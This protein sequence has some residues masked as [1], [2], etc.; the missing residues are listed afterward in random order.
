MVYDREGMEKEEILD[1]ATEAYTRKLVKVAEKNQLS[2]SETA[3][4]LL[5]PRLGIHR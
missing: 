1:L 4:R 2:L 5:D 3:N